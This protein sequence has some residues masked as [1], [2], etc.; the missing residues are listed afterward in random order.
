LISWFNATWFWEQVPREVQPSEQEITRNP[1]VPPLPPPLSHPINAKAA[2][3]AASGKRDEAI[4]M[5]PK[6]WG[7]VG[8]EG[9]L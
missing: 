4:L 7:V 9:E 6:L 2:A 3:D 5:G 1:L 8:S